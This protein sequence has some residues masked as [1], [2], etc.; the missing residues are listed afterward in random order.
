VKTVFADAGAEAER[1]VF[2][3]VDVHHGGAPL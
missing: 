2:G 3:G 1:E